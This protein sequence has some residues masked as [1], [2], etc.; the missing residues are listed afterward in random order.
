MPSTGACLLPGVQQRKQEGEA[1][2]SDPGCHMAGQQNLM[3]FLCR[4]GLEPIMTG[5]M[6]QPV[7]SFLRLY[8]KKGE[9]EFWLAVA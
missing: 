1:G 2:A 6:L 5:S 9:R 4:I 7:A 8:F 3:P